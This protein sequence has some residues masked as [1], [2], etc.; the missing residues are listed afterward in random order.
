MAI[1]LIAI[2]GWLVAIVLWLRCDY[3]Q[4]VASDLIVETMTAAAERDLAVG[5]ALDAAA[6]RATCPASRCPRRPEALA[7]LRA[8]QRSPAASPHPTP[9]ATR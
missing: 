7:R 2:A 9:D 4:G 1:Y 6:E 5:R 3:L 8:V